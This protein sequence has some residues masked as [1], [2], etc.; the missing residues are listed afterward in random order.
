MHDDIKLPR[1]VISGVERRWLNKL[2]Q[3]AC[4]WKSA[5]RT[6]AFE[7]TINGG[8]RDIPVVV[9]RARRRSAVPGRRQPAWPDTPIPAHG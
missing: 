7:R 4:A 2:E 1:H 9:R 3:A 6:T 8:G 5:Q